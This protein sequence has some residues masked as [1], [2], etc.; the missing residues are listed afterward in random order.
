ICQFVCSVSSLY[1]GEWKA[2]DSPQPT[3]PSWSIASSTK[4]SFVVN[5]PKLVVN[6]AF[7]SIF[8]I[9]ILIYLMFI[10]FIIILF[11]FFNFFYNI[12]LYNV[13]YSSSSFN[14]YL[15]IFTI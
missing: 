15:D 9:L 3:V 12:D 7:N 13:N 8:I 5:V 11:V 10:F 2:T 4:K 6:G 1:Q 14:V